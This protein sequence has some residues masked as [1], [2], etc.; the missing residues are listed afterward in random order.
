M[1]KEDFVLTIQ[2]NT[3]N[4]K[5]THNHLGRW[6]FKEGTWANI[7]RWQKKLSYLIRALSAVPTFGEMLKFVNLSFAMLKWNHSVKIFK[8]TNWIGVSVFGIEAIDN[9]RF[10]EGEAHT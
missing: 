10:K 3:S 5:I 2:S 8:L 1:F 9:W 6:R 7:S 4:G